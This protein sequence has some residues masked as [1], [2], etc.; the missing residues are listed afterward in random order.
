MDWDLLMLG[1]V[2]MKKKEGSCLTELVLDMNSDC[3]IS[4]APGDSMMNQI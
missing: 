3:S 1:V 4:F 2:Q